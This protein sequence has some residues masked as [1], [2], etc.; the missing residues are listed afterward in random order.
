M[1]DMPQFDRDQR[2]SFNDMHQFVGKSL[3]WDF[4]IQLCMGYDPKMYACRRTKAPH[5]WGMGP[6]FQ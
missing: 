6:L 1:I 2:E 3:K 5:C 4:W